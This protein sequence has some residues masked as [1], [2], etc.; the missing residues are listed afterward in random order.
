M[1]RS[2]GRTD[3]RS[4]RESIAAQ[5]VVDL[6]HGEHVGLDS[7]FLAG[8]VGQGSSQPSVGRWQSGWHMS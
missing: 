3:G 5:L 6:Q 7:L 2:Y 8:S 1:S 4:R